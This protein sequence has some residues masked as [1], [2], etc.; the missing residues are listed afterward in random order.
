MHLIGAAHRGRGTR[1]K[2]ATFPASNVKRPT[3][4]S[5]ATAIDR[6]IASAEPV[7]KRGVPMEEI[8][9]LLN[10]T[11]SSLGA[12]LWQPA[13]RKNGCANVRPAAVSI[14]PTPSDMGGAI[15]LA[16][17]ADLACDS[18]ICHF[19]SQLCVQNYPGIPGGAV[20]PPECES[21]PASCNGVP[22]CDCLRTLC[23]SLNCDES[24]SWQISYRS[25]GYFDCIGY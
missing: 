14:C 24:S 21:L 8:V 4:R 23:P 19:P 15:D 2:R 17:S 22:S 11:P 5:A 12:L 7:L 13:F 10:V 18:A 20:P 25:T 16:V 1:E 3:E 6:P 9:R